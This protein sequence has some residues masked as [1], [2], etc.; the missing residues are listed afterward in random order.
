[1][2]CM[3]MEKGPIIC[4]PNEEEVVESKFEREQIKELIISQCSHVVPLLTITTLSDMTSL[5][6]L[7]M[8]MDDHIV[9]LLMLGYETSFMP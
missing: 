5:I 6:P 7:Y 1:M 9:F 2:F 8:K 4:L 3:G